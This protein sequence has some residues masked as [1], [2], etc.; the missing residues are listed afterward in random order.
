MI[1]KINFVTKFWWKK[2]AKICAKLTKIFSKNKNF[3][4][5]K[6]DEKNWWK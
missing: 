2:L 4:D 1:K 5:K 3:F 6:K